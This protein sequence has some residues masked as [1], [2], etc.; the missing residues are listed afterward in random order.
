M[1]GVACLFFAFV[2]A[3]S[4]ASIVGGE[5]YLMYSAIAVAV[6]S[7]FFYAATRGR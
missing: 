2:F 3:N 5:L 1:F 4:Y 6:A 7:A